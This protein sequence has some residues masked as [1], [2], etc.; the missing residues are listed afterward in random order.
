MSG[1]I[2]CGPTKAKCK[3]GV[4]WYEFR[5]NKWQPI[6]LVRIMKNDENEGQSTSCYAV[7]IHNVQNILFS[8]ESH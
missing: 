5:K 6:W 2:V 1:R 7:L 4:N 3:S 8:E